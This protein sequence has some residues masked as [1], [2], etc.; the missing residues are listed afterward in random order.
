M[1]NLGSKISD[2]LITDK[3]EIKINIPYDVKAV[4]RPR[5][6][7]RSVMVEYKKWRSELRRESMYVCD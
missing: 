7:E 1:K 5:I 3:G 4:D 6:E 2:Y